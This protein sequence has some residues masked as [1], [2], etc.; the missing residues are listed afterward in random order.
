MNIQ[1]LI[2]KHEG[3]RLEP[4]QDSV[5]VWTVGYGHNC[6]TKTISKYIAEML[7]GEDIRDAFQD[8]QRFHWFEDLDEVREAVVVDMLFNLG[9]PR[10]RKFKKFIGWMALGEYEL[11]SVEMLDSKWAKQVGKRAIEL[12]HMMKLGEW[13]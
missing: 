11:A 13:Q 5:G 7:L 1:E 6:Q 3:L 4:Y 2:A 9:L 10:F 12:S 8:C